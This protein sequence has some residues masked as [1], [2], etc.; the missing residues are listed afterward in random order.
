[1]RTHAQSCTRA[2]EWPAD[3]SGTPYPAVQ[4]GER[5]P[6]SRG[7]AAV[8]L[9][10]VLRDS[11][12]GTSCLCLPASNG[13]SR[14]IGRDLSTQVVMAEIASNALK[15]YFPLSLAD[16]NCGVTLGTGS[17]GRVKFSTHKVVP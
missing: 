5:E 3:P 10:A 14:Y 15:E 4:P 12:G 2:F 1:M 17:F 9:F 8:V 6:V 16:F 7:R 13:F 11:P